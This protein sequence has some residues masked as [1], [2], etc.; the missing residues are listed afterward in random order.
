MRANNLLQAD[1]GRTVSR[2]PIKYNIAVA[3]SDA[4][5]PN[6]YPLVDNNNENT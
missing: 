2:E 3:I 5:G 1:D 6:N 4:I